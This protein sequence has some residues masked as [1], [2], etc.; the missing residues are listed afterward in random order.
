MRVAYDKY[1]LAYALDNALKER[2]EAR[3]E[4]ES[5]KAMLNIA[6][7]NADELREEVNQWKN[8]LKLLG[9]L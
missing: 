8:E 2:D 5:Y 3:A 9:Y 1:Q 4:A 7:E 6:R